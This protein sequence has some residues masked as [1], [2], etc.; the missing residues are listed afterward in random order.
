MCTCVNCTQR[1]LRVCEQGVSVSSLMRIACLSPVLQESLAL[2]GADPLTSIS[3][4]LITQGRY[5]ADAEP[6]GCLPGLVLLPTRGLPLLAPVL[7]QQ[8]PGH[9]R[10]QHGLQQLRELV[11]LQQEQQGGQGRLFLLELHV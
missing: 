2:S 7:H 6:A 9:R 3:W 1:S 10:V 8:V 4:E 5:F 11:V